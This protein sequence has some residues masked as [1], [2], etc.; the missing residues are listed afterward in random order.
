ML[1]ILSLCFCAGDSPPYES[2]GRLSLLFTIKPKGFPSPLQVGHRHMTW[3][4][5]VRLIYP[6]LE[7]R[8]RKYE[9]AGDLRTPGGS[10]SPPSSI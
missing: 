10:S 2:L 3:A 9:E 8:A 7:P 6:E 5:P 1:S 4:P